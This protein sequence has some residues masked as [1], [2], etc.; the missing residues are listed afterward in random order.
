MRYAK[1]SRDVEMTCAVMFTS[2]RTFTELIKS[3]ACN[4][5]MVC[6][7]SINTDHKTSLTTN[8]AS[9]AFVSECFL[10]SKHNR[11]DFRF[12]QNMIPSK[13]A[14]SEKLCE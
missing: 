9:W 4:I 11:H 5:A 1:L 10:L 2:V 8:I 3:R 12:V 6:C 7:N 13:L 14:K